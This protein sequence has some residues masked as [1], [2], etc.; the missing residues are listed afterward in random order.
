MDSPLPMVCDLHAHYQ[1][2]L[3]PPARAAPRRLLQAAQRHEGLS[4]RMRAELVGLASLV[5]NYRSVFSGPR[6]RIE[7]LHEGG[8]GV[9]L[10]VLYGFFDEIDVADGPRPHASYLANLE[11]QLDLVEA[12]VAGR[13]ATVVAHGPGEL[14]AARRDD[15]LAL[16]HC[17]EGGF[18]TA[19]PT[20]TSS[21]TPTAC[22]C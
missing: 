13:P 10:S 19:T 9:V 8:V 18:C 12:S 15:L 14:A 11:R 2:H 20:P 22:G 6:V 5:A 21:A 3:V 16:V 1:M 17:V 7:Y 4:D